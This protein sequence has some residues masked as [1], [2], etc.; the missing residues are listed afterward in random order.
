MTDTVNRNALSMA[1]DVAGRVS[2]ISGWKNAGPRQAWQ[3]SIVLSLLATTAS[4]QT[5]SQQAQN[6]LPSVTVTAPEAKRRPTTATSDTTAARRTR[7]TRAARRPEQPVQPKPFEETQA[8]RTGTVGYYV[9]STSIATRTNTPI[10]NI[11]QSLNVISREMIND[12]N[13]GGL[14]DVTRY[15]PSVAVHQGEGNRDELVIRGVDSSA[16]FFVNGFRDDV[17]IYRDIYNTQSIEVLKGPSAITFGRGSGGGL[18]NRTLKEADGVYRYEATGQTGSWGDRRVSVD[19]GQAVNENV[20]VR[21]NAFYEGADGFRDFNHLERY[22]FN[23]TA[24]FKVDDNTKVKLS[25]E[26]YHDERTADRG[27][28]SL[29]PVGGAHAIQSGHAV[30]TQW[31]LLDLLRQ[32]ESQHG[33]GYRPDRHGVH[34]T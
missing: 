31:R 2:V 9:N 33:A 17:Q 22:G 6:D 13:Y 21:L 29:T 27:N 5:P 23:P 3:A 20:A 12:Q 25:Y 11:P 34:R 18:L 14:T 4:A 19:A 10:V 28:P 8:Q 32:P 1:A 15:V 26:Y 16:N 30:C 24:T 7:A